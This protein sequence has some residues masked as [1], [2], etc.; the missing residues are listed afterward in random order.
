[1]S[2]GTICRCCGERIQ[3][4]ANANPNICLACAQL[5]EDESP[6]D[7]VRETGADAFMLELVANSTHAELRVGP[8]EYDRSGGGRKR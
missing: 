2:L 4:R 7:L 3:A 5:L 6:F 1:M 8:A